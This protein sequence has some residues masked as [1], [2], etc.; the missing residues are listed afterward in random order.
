VS[1][2]TG[3]TAYS[4]SVR[5]PIVTPDSKVLML[6]PVAPHNLNVRPI[7]APED[8]VI[9]VSFVSKEGALVTLDNRS[10]DAQREGRFTV[11]KADCYANCVRLH[12]SNFINALRD[13]LL[14]G[15]D[16]RNTI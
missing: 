10:F 6:S 16:R 14:W 4:L 5:G 2:P 7:V 11:T 15:E 13:K 12:N 9:E 3:S 1:N 8:S